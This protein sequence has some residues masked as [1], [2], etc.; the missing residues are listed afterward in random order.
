MRPLGSGGIG[1]GR[2]PWCIPISGS[3]LIWFPLL[4]SCSQAHL[5]LGDS[6]VLADPARIDGE[7]R[8]AW[9]P[10]FCRSGHRDTSLDE[11]DP[12]LDMRRRFKAVMELL[13]AMIRCGVSL[14]R[15]LELSAQWDRILVIGPLF[16]VTLDD[17]QVVRGVGLGDFYHGVCGI[18]RRLCDFIHSIVVHRRDEAIRGWRNWIREDPLV[19]PYRWLRPDL[20]LPPPFL[21]CK[22]HL[23]PGGSGVLADPARIDGEFRKAWLTYFCRSGQREASLEEFTHEAALAS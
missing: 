15:S 20:V 8:K 23:S 10:Y 1:F 21:Q 6:G 17:L 19:H 12:L 13:D 3:G 7:F 11:F 2:I 4:L 14:S 9:L 5:T 22:P 18:H 16:P